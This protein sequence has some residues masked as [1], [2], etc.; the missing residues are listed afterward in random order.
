MNFVFAA[1]TNLN[2]LAMGPLNPMSSWMIAQVRWIEF[3][4]LRNR[5]LVLTEDK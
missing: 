2:L 3:E 1:I 5:P 4:D